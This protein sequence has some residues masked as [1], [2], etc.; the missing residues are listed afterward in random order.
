MRIAF[1]RIYKHS[2]FCAKEIFVAN[3][4]LIL[5]VVLLIGPSAFGRV[6]RLRGITQIIAPSSSSSSS[7]G[8]FSTVTFAPPL[9]NTAPPPLTTTS[10]FVTYSASFP[11]VTFS[12]N[13]GQFS[14]DT[15]NIANLN[16]QKLGSNFAVIASSR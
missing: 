14:F 2:L 6:L 4:T 12:W 11:P 1:W 15:T 5:L 13:P 10:A 7:G 8:T 16:P 3:M 9:G